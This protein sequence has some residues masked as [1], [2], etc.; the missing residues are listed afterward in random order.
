MDFF[1]KKSQHDTDA[2][3]A[4]DVGM[5][6]FQVDERGNLEEAPKVGFRP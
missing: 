1:T 4:Q 6:A 3:S 2:A 5:K